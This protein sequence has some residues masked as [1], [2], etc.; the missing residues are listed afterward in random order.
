M[1]RRIAFDRC[2]ANVPPIASNLQKVLHI[3]GCLGPSVI[4][5]RFTTGSWRITLA[6]P[7]IEK[8]CRWRRQTS[9]SRV[10]FF[11]I[12]KEESYPLAASELKGDLPYILAA[13]E[14]F[15]VATET[16][17]VLKDTVSTPYRSLKN[18]GGSSAESLRSMS[19]YA[20][21]DVAHLPF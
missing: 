16:S 17:S 5:V 19:H 4:C 14:D 3:A 21:D 15:L 13:S 2:F 8:Y 1:Q 7:Q 12:V 11:S 10:F 6:R 20:E 9:N 18:G